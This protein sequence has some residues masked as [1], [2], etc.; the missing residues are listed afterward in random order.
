VN[1]IDLAIAAFNFLNSVFGLGHIGTLCAS[2]PALAL[3]FGA[4]SG[5]EIAQ[6]TLRSSLTGTP[7]C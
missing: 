7:T 2:S 5:L 6:A 3:H 1:F 4:Q